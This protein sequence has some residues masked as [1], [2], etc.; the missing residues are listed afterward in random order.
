MTARLIAGENIGEEI[1]FEEFKE[2]FGSD[3]PVPMWVK[4]GDKFR[5]LLDLHRV[6]PCGCG[7]ELPIWDPM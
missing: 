5:L 2:L 6:C 4:R 7:R 3:E 1:D